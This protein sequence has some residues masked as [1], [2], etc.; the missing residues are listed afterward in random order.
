M[1][2]KQI[3]IL[4]ESGHLS[5]RSVSPISNTNANC[6]SL[7]FLKIL[8]PFFFLYSITHSFSLLQSY[9]SFLR[10]HSCPFS[11]FLI[12]RFCFFLFFSIHSLS[13]KSRHISDIF[14]SF[15]FD[16]GLNFIRKILLRGLLWQ[17]GARSRN[18]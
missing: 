7:F 17:T 14:A 9:P 1:L 4:G 8:R 13:K 10:R 18:E 16:R 12:L 2:G 11:R 3:W 15:R 5:N 6:V